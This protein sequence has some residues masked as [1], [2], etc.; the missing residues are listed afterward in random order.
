M[1]DHKPCYNN[2]A[3]YLQSFLNPRIAKDIINQCVHELQ[4]KDFDTIAFRGLSG[5]LIAPQIAAL[6]GKDLVAV[7]KG[8]TCH[9]SN[10]VEGNLQ[11]VRYVIVD[12]L[13]STGDTV[14]KIME[15]INRVAPEATCIGVL[16]AVVFA[17]N[18]NGWIERGDVF[19]TFLSDSYQETLRERNAE[20]T[21]QRQK[22]FK[23]ITTDGVE[24]WMYAFE[25]ST[26][27]ENVCT[28]IPEPKLLTEAVTITAQ[29]RLDRDRANFEK[30]CKANVRIARMF[31]D[32]AGSYPRITNSWLRNTS[33]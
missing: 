5:A 20:K 14:R 17:P 15:E 26:K 31:T 6:M 10:M 3:Y 23:Q 9:S 24:R 4:G 12:D 8:E 13:M 2:S 28:P 22:D 19:D 11:T 33:R 21:R 30:R 29:E 27:K 16:Q 25:D 1:S 18:N 7:R 32:R